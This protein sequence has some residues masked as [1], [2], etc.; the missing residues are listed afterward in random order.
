MTPYIVEQTCMSVSQSVMSIV[1]FRYCPDSHVNS[2]R[3]P[4]VWS[5]CE[6]LQLRSDADAPGIS[7]QSGRKVPEE[8]RA[9]CQVSRFL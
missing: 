9:D 6:Q 4:Q 7:E 3:V 1:Y 8:D 2:G 5:A